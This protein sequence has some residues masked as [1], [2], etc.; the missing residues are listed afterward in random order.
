MEHLHSR[1]FKLQLPHALFTLGKSP[2]I[3]CKV[4]RILC[5]LFYFYFWTKLAIIF[6]LGVDF[7]APSNQIDGSIARKT[8]V[9]KFHTNILCFSVN[10]RW[11]GGENSMFFLKYLSRNSFLFYVVS[12]TGAQHF[13]NIFITYSSWVVV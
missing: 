12:Q 6:H 11:F 5:D 13:S 4:D 1:I 8:H 9:K 3:G 10:G 2:L 7:C